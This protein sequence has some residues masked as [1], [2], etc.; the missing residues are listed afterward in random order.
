MSKTYKKKRNK[1]GKVLSSWQLPFIF[2]P[3]DLK[4]DTYVK[5]GEVI[6]TFF[7]TNRDNKWHLCFHRGQTSKF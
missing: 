6:L 7:I 4:L 3:K 5:V 1:D 2:R